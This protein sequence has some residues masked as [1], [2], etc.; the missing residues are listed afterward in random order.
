MEIILLKNVKTTNVKNKFAEAFDRVLAE[1]DYVGI[2]N[3]NHDLRVTANQVLR[4]L[5]AELPSAVGLHVDQD[6]DKNQN[7]IFLVS[8]PDWEKQGIELPKTLDVENVKLKLLPEKDLYRFVYVID[9]VN[10]DYPLIK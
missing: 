4:R 10:S 8:G 9:D 2:K 5:K 6:I 1:S 7:N 3:F